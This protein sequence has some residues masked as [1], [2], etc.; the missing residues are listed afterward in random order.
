MIMSDHFLFPYLFNVQPI[1]IFKCFI[2]LFFFPVVC[3][4]L[5]VVVVIFLLPTSFF[6]NFKSLQRGDRM[7]EG[8]KPP[9]I[10]RCY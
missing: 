9:Q 6:C 8:N 2:S 3:V 10:K 4:L 5:F 1:F 7:R